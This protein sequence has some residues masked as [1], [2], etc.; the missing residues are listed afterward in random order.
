MQLNPLTLH[1][2]QT[3]AE[4]DELY[5]KL[6]NIKILA[7]G[8]FLVNSLK[9]LKNKGLKT[10]DN[11]ISLKKIPELH[12]ISLENGILSLGA[13]VTLDD[14]I[15]SSVIAKEFGILKTVSSQIATT[16]IRHMA[17]V[18][19][20]LTCR[21]TWTELPTI[22]VALNARLHFTSNGKEEIVEAENFF[23]N[24]AK[25][26][27][28]LTK[29]T[30][31]KEENLVVSYRRATRTAAIDIPML[32]VCIKTCLKNKTFAD[33][34][35]TV[36]NGTVFCQRDNLLENFLNQKPFSPTLAT[37]AIGQLKSPIYETKDDDYKRHM[38]EVSIK[39]AL[40]EITGKAK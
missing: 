17:T 1:L 2:P 7:G 11:I 23:K 31:P 12:A 28:I 40:E 4:A 8:T 38:F 16:P 20:N 36:N 13:M 27:K 35:V 30:I 25:T 21:Y 29:I 33:T 32:S 9:N 10:P 34:Q 3:I 24:A 39:Q 6:D 15:N 5:A 22:M 19:G 14:I 18:G 37:E 26:N